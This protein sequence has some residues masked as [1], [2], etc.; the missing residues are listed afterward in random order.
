MQFLAS[1]LPWVQVVLSVSLVSLI[2]IQQGEGSLG[3][4]FG[5]S[6]SSGGFRKKRGLEKT[7]FNLTIVISILFVISTIIALFI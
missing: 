3:S 1:I 2:L 4:A 5:G 6:D 7:L